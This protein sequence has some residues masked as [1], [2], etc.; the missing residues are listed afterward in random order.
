[1]NGISLRPFV[2]GDEFGMG[3]EL[4]HTGLIVFKKHGFFGVFFTLGIDQTRLDFFNGPR[5]S[6][7]TAINNP[8]CSLSNKR[9]C[10]I[11]ELDHFHMV[12]KASADWV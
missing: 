3:K 9:A 12:V 5:L 4:I 11:F 7:A 8:T 2:S 6:A 10:L 1:V